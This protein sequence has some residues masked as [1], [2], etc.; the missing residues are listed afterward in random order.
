MR[1]RPSNWTYLVKDLYKVAAQY[2][3]FTLFLGLLFISHS[4]VKTNSIP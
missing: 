2:R 4:L 3:R 1:D